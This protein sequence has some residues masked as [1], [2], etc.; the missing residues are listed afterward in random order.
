MNSFSLELE[1]SIKNGIGYF[2]RTADN[3]RILSSDTYLEEP[4][5]VIR[6]IGISVS[7]GCKIGCR[8]CFTNKYLG[9]RPL[10]AKELCDQ[11]EFV[12]NNQPN[13]YPK[14][15]L[16]ISLKQMGDPMLNSESVL[17]ALKTLSL[18]YP[19][20]MLVVST[21]APKI[22][23]SF[24]ADLQNL[25]NDGANIRLQFSCH[26][27]SD[28]ERKQLSPR[29]PMMSLA[30]IGQITDKWNGQLVTLNFVIFEGYTYDVKTLEKIFNPSKVFIKI[31][32]VDPNSQTEKNNFSDGIESQKNMFVEDLRK[33]GYK[34]AFRNK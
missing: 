18:E 7:S 14:S 19:E 1:K 15:K 20:S 2:L 28:A 4:E 23:S 29:M 8:Y 13:V 17:S 26:T 24:F 6:K 27:T 11:V 34:L 22:K 16:K 25:Q 5:G 31:N 9:Y 10:S 30:E 33:A 12:I 32:Y 21:S 3:F